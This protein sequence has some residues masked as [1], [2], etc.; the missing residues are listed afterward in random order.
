M[1]FLLLTSITLPIALSPV[2]STLLRHA[3][4]AYEASWE[5]PWIRTNWWNWRGSWIVFGGPGG[6]YLGATFLGY[7][8]LK[9][10]RSTPNTSPKLGDI[11]QEPSLLAAIGAL[12]AIALS[13]FCAVSKPASFF[14]F[15]NVSYLREDQC[16]TIHLS[17]SFHHQPS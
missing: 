7:G 10:R 5:D 3:K 17:G 15:A 8:A 14:F 11:V 1:L 4:N 16:L 6:R 13:A 9:G 2:V 12:I